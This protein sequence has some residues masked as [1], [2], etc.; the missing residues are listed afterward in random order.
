LRPSRHRAIANT[1][2]RHRE[3][4]DRASSARL[5]LEPDEAMAWRTDACRRFSV[6][7]R[8]ERLRI[9]YRD[10]GVAEESVAMWLRR[11]QQESAAEDARSCSR[12]VLSSSVTMRCVR[13]GTSTFRRRWGEVS[14]DERCRL[15][16]RAPRRQ[17]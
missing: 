2:S 3:H 1:E 6:I 15:G 5:V 12:G 14:G 13:P 9:E 8:G 10:S 17:T 11:G 7:V 16:L 4:Q